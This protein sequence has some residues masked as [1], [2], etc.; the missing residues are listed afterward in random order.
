MNEQDNYPDNLSV[1]MDLGEIE[2]T[3]E[4]LLSLRPGSKV[5]FVRPQTLSGCLRLSGGEWAYVDIALSESSMELTV[6]ELAILPP[7]KDQICS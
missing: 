1:S 3:V 7:K 4:E 5:S 6:R 2:L